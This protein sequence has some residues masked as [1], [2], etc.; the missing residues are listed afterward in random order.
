M[1][2]LRN[3]SIKQK[4]FAKNFVETK[5]L[6]DAA[7]AGYNCKNRNSARITGFYTLKNPMVQKEVERLLEEKNIS[8][9]FMFQRLQEGIG[10]KV[11]ASYQ[12]T[13]T[14]TKIPDHNAAYKWWEAAAKIKDYFPAEKVDQRNLN[15]DLQL[16]TMPKEEFTD[17][18]RGL[19]LSLKSGK[20]KEKK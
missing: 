2:K 9:D 16:E 7:L 17:L 19:L 15:I 13:A 10:A 6:A 12:G 8:D 11:V 20:E 1:P 18:L 3:L 14:E 5:N 4:L